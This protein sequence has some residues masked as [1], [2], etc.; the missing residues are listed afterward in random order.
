V[1]DTEQANTMTWRSFIVMLHMLQ[2]SR[3][4]AARVFVTSNQQTR[5]VV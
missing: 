2:V 5:P 3:V 4:A 1:F